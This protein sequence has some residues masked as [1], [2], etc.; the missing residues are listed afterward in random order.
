MVW[1]RVCVYTRTDV[2]GKS[3]CT[4]D[5]WGRGECVYTRTD[6][7]GECVSLCVNTRTDWV[8][9]IVCTPEQMCVH[10]DRWGG[11]VCVCECTPE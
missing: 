1:G 2:E 10:Q 3:V 5:R 6:G 9:E 8:G 11:G 4:Q 7:V